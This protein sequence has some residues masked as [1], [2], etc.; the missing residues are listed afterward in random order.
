VTRERFAKWL[1]ISNRSGNIW[2][3]M[4]KT[5]EGASMRIRPGL[6]LLL[7]GL[8]LSSAAPAGNLSW[9]GIVR[10]DGLMIPFAQFDGMKWLLCWPEADSEDDQKPIEL[11]AIPKA[12]LGS[13][14]VMPNTWRFLSYDYKLSE[15]RVGKPLKVANY[16]SEIWGV[17]TDYSPIEKL[18]HTWPYPKAGLAFVG[19]LDVKRPEQ[20]D[21]NSHENERFIGFIKRTFI[22]K[23][24]GLGKE[25]PSKAKYGEVTR[26]GIPLQKE[27]RNKNDITIETLIKMG[28]HAYYFECRRVYPTIEE[29]PQ[30]ESLH[31]NGWILEEL[32]RSDYRLIDVNMIRGAG[33][34][35]ACSYNVLGQLA[36]DNALYVVTVI[37]C[38]EWEFFAIL[39]VKEDGLVTIVKAW[40]GGC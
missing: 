34:T 33:P 1:I 10:S 18:E 28:A 3:E 6:F 5:K 20:V 38:Y 11:S 12:W 19:D 36:I 21:L 2:I 25:D 13:L 15:L 27:L 24:D 35:S 30:P 22:E 26:G 4:A 32:A 8:M 39:R 17:T 40:A 31:I 9:F 29:D 23:E 7:F 37:D 14:A 16:C